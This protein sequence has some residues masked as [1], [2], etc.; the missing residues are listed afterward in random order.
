MRK[1]RLKWTSTTMIIVL[2]ALAAIF[3]LLRSQTAPQAESETVTGSE[4]FENKGCS[5]CHYTDSEQSLVGPGLKGIL[6]QD[7]LPVSG[8]KATEKNIAEQ[9]KNPYK[10]MP[11]YAD[12]LTE[13]QIDK[14][15]DYLKNL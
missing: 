1:T 8:W 4:L 5:Q 7:E 2:T 6:E 14:L 9:L 12:R 10:N 11:S 13:N 15:I 3:A